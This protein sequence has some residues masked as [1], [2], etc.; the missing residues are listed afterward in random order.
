MS[1]TRAILVIPAII[2]LAVSAIPIFDIGQAS[3]SEEDGF[4]YRYVDSEDPDPKV[5]F[6]YIDI[7]N[8]PDVVGRDTS[9]TQALIHADLGFTFNYYG[10][11]Y[12]K[13]YISSFCAMS[14]VENDPDAFYYT[15]WGKDMPS[16]QEPRGLMAVYFA[17]YNCRTTN[18]DNLY[19]LQ[20]EIDGEK[21]FIV[22]WN[23]TSGGKMQA[24]LFQGGMIKFQ[25]DS[26][27]G[28]TAGSYVTIGIEN[29]SGTTGT[30]LTNYQ[31]QSSPLFSLPYAIAFVRD[32]IEIKNLELKD[33]DGRWEDTIYAGSRP[34][35]FEVEAKHSKGSEEML[36][37]L[38]TLGSNP[39]Q[40]NIKLIYLHRNNTFT[41][42]SGFQ[43]AEIDPEISVY[44]TTGKYLTVQFGVNFLFDYPSQEMRNVTAKASG[45]S[46][47]PSIVDAGEIYWVETEVEWD[48]LELFAYRSSDNRRLPD[49]SYVGGGESI[50][51]SG[52]RVVYENSDIQPDPSTFNVNITDNYGTFKSANIQ[53]GSGLDVNWRTIEDS[54]RMTWTFE[55]AGFPAFSMLSESF[56]YS[57]NVDITSPDAVPDLFILP[58]SETD[59]PRTYDN[60]DTVFVKW[61]PVEDG[62]AGMGEYIIRADLPSEG[63]SIEKRV[64]ASINT[65]RIGNEIGKGLPEGEVNISILPVDDVGNIGP[66]N[67]IKIRID[68]TGPSFE[69]IDPKPGQWATR[70]TPVIKVRLTDELTGVEGE[71]VRY[72]VSMDGGYTFDEW[73]SFYYF[74]SDNEIVRTIEPSLKEGKD[75]I[76]EIRGT[77]VAGSEEIF[78]EKIPIWI[79]SRSPE[80]AMSEPAVDKN[81]TTVDWLRSMN[82]P[83]RI[84]VHDWKGSGIEPGSISYSFSTDG[85]QSFSTD[86]P[87]QGEGYNNSQGY[88]EYSFAIKQDWKEGSDNIIRVKALDRVG[89]NTTS[90]FTIRFDMSPVVRLLSPTPLS[91]LS[92]NRSISL[93]LEVTDPDGGDD[94]SVT[95][96]SNIDGTIAT[97]TR[98]EVFL[99]PGEHIILVTVEDGVHVVKEIYTFEVRASILDDPRF[100]DSDNDGMNDSYEKSFGLNPL[101]D[102]SANDLDGDGH[103]NLDEYYAGTDPTGKNSYPGSEIE[104][105][106]FPVIPL[107]L[108]LLSIILFGGAGFLLAREVN[109]NRSTQPPVPGIPIQPAYGNLPPSGT[110][111]RRGQ[112]LPPPRI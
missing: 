105:E 47:V 91:E 85:G 92:D 42:L 83:L 46:A 62:G 36:S 7:R 107:I 32:E 90:T 60:D 72:R 77:D 58:D 22:E 108:V 103:S 17:S 33:G 16:N 63:F 112:Y 30:I 55:M 104:E 34:Y 69:V 27:P 50:G 71:S 52:F 10:N 82:E 15:Y 64:P 45:R 57:L 24:L 53:K 86:I 89:R 35:L 110:S 76:L 8:D 93:I 11:T 19:T 67:W 20:T 78:S 29:P 37:I 38:L 4:G 87:L 109:K 102:D 111:P 23:P 106:E 99:S 43:Y 95:W 98:A 56:E 84:K 2:L 14:F 101:A 5:D 88:H 1:M 6:N 54:T 51:F 31:Y 80:I 100:K 3:E 75:N 40:E 74:G 68:L 13:V 94:I 28:G 73:S 96:L 61:D 26:I 79:D 59:T 41:Q 48:P 97:G 9:Q 21:V 18:N 81:G 12:S 66:S 39:G 70:T 49:S 44:S 25:Y 65:T